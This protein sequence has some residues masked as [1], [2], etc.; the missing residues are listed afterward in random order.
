MNDRS[1]VIDAF[2]EAVPRHADAEALVVVDVFRTTTTALT[3][4]LRGRPCYPVL[5]VD[6]AWAKHRAV[7]GS[8]LAGEQD[9]SIPPGFELDN[10]PTAIAN[11][12]DD[13]PI[14]LLSTAGTKALSLA[15]PTQSVYAACLR[16]WSAQARALVDRHDHVALIGAGARGDFRMEDAQCCAWI[17]DRLVAAGYR[18]ANATTTELVESWRDTAPALLESPSATWLR[19]TGRDADIAFTSEHLDDVDLVV[20]MQDGT[21]VLDP[22]YEPVPSGR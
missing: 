15:A 12:D 14:V 1:V 2:P 10:S 22:V 16:N 9:G 6:E 8:V 3:A 13:R 5:S 4:L 17:A 7:P 21:L 11:D 19:S 18:P 20:S